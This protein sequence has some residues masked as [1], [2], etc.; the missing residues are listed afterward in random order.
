M[1][2]ISRQAVIN[3]LLIVLCSSVL[4]GTLYLCKDRE[5]TVENVVLVK[6]MSD[7]MGKIRSDSVEYKWEAKTDESGVV[8]LNVPTDNINLNFDLSSE[9]NNE[10]FES[11]YDETIIS[12]EPLDILEIGETVEI[13]TAD[14]YVPDYSTYNSYRTPLSE[15]KKVR[16]K[17]R[18]ATSPRYSILNINGDYVTL[19]KIAE[20]GCVIIFFDTL[21][22]DKLQFIKDTEKYYKKYADRVP[23]ILLNS[24]LNVSNTFKTIDKKLSDFGIKIDYPIYMDKDKTFEY[25]VDSYAETTNCVLI[26]SDCYVFDAVNVGDKSS[27]LGIK[28]KALIRE[29]EQLVEDNKIIEETGE[30]ESLYS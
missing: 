8:F 27:D 12:L 7:N 21:T 17:G 28:M 4:G 5:E 14:S 1:K 23:I 20:K 15:A 29:E 24:T 22:D 2:C 11:N 30:Y 10:G 25:I 3:L 16:N 13:Y 6:D 18:V 19:E 26:N 9:E